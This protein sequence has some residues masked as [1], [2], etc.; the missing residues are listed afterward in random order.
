LIAGSLAK[1]YAKALVDVAA[2]SGELEPV[3][4]ELAEFAELLRGQREL[5]H[6]FANPSIL[7]RNKLTAFAEIA[8]RMGLRTL[9]A[10]FLRVVV[11]A[12]RL[13]ALDGILRAYEGLMDD[14]LN[15]VRAQVTTAAALDPATEQQLRRR[16]FERLGKEVVLEVRQ[17]P[18]LLG[19]IVTRVGSVVYD[20]SLRTQLAMLRA[21]LM[22]G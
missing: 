8:G 2:A 20:G 12:G 15:R 18:A 9:T 17:D 14:R 11:E 22:Q 19:G 10:T 7:T 1:R 13:G 4:R 6:F 5:R 16:L 3:A 21:E